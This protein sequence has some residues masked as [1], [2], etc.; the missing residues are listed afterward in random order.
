MAANLKPWEQQPDESG[1]AFL[2]FQAYLKLGPSRT[3]RDAY[4]QRT[5]NAQAT[6]AGGS[7]NKWVKQHR[8]QE[9][10]R[11]HDD[12]IAGLHQ[13]GVDQGAV[14]RGRKFAQ[15]RDEFIA[16]G[17]ERWRNRL[18]QTD[19]A[20][21]MPLTT[22]TVH[23]D[24]KTV[25]IEATDFE[26]HRKATVV[27]AKAQESALVLINMGLEIESA[28]AAEVAER[29]SAARPV[30]EISDAQKRLEAW[31]AAQRKSYLTLTPVPPDD[32]PDD[33]TTE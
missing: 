31:R 21:T 24:G 11:A 3:V 23:R 2:A 26:I 17:I 10:A 13:K 18:R 30:G 8:W 12:H 9:R 28:V 25:V 1:T 14:R 22:Q 27:A 19:L 32:P 4:R 7:W 6:Q 16:E 20:A 5:G 29:D 33:P 15:I